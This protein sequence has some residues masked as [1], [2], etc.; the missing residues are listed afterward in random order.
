MH[1]HIIASIIMAQFVAVCCFLFLFAVSLKEW[2]CVIFLVGNI[3]NNS[4]QS[5]DVKQMFLT[6]FITVKPASTFCIYIF[7]LAT[8]CVVIAETDGLYLYFKECAIQSSNSVI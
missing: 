4:K 8:V 3:V 7:F 1:S 5:D 2:V 6:L